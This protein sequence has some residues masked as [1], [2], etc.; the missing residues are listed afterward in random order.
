[1]AKRPLFLLLSRRDIFR[2]LNPYA[3]SVFKEIF[4][5]EFLRPQK[6]RGQLSVLNALKSF[7]ILGPSRRRELLMDSSGRAGRSAQSNVLDQKFPHCA[8]KTKDGV[9]R[10]QPWGLAIC[11]AD[12][13]AY[14][15]AFR[16]DGGPIMSQIRL[17]YESVIR[18][19]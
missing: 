9:A 15:K 4:E 14:L 17:S 5:S 16:N 10:A 13:S 3:P 6:S 1:M 2:N 11:K 7:A 12:H 19:Q 18:V 8:S